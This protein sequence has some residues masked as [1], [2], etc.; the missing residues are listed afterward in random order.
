MTLYRPYCTATNCLVL[1][2]MVDELSVSTC[3]AVVQLYRTLRAVFGYAQFRPGQLGAAVAAMHGQ[4]VFVQMCTGSGK[5]VC[6][7]LP[8][9]AMSISS[10]GVVISPLNAIMDVMDEQ[11]Y[12]LCACLHRCVCILIFSTNVYPDIKVEGVGGYCYSYYH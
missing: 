11:V 8:P 4:D 5:S 7:F 1:A 12:L 2:G 3:P 9:L 10:V 6:M